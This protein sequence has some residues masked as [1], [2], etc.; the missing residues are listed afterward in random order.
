MYNYYTPQLGS[1]SS[2]VKKA[3]S[4]ADPRNAISQ[5][6]RTI[7]TGIGI[8][9]D[10]GKLAVDSTKRALTNPTGIV[11]NVIEDV[12]QAAGVTAKAVTKP[13]TDEITNVKKDFYSG[14]AYQ[15][16]QREAA[17]KAAAKKKREEE[18]MIKHMQEVREANAKNANEA[19]R[20]AGEA[21]KQ[22]AAYKAAQA[23]KQHY[24]EVAEANAKN[25][26]EASRSAGVA[27]ASNAVE[28][29]YRIENAD[30]QGTQQLRDSA[31]MAQNSAATSEQMQYLPE[32]QVKSDFSKYLLI[33]GGFLL[34]AYI[35][36]NGGK[37]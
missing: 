13:V 25:A 19:S 1:L 33:G 34:L 4:I 32:V 16:A 3:A 10:A 18:A 30:S 28:N 36:K 12:K 26:N 9:K 8:T 11:D 14:G 29:A 24:R 27:S 15:S 22:T 35:L 21:S 20:S 5:A 31:A 17:A 6:E 7:S 37:E 2:L 23:Q